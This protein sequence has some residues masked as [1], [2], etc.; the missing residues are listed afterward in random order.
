MLLWGSYLSAAGTHTGGGGGLLLRLPGSQAGRAE[1][2]GMGPWMR[3]MRAGS[4]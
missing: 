3:I 4:R 2:W 1:L